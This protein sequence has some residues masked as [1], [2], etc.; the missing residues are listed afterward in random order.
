MPSPNKSLIAPG[1]PGLKS[2]MCRVRR[3]KLALSRNTSSR[4]VELPS[5]NFESNQV[6]RRQRYH[7]SSSVRAEKFLQQADGR[8]TFLRAIVEACAASVAVLDESGK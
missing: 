7:G 4:I 6:T 8:E 1:S 3:R 2:Q 5:S